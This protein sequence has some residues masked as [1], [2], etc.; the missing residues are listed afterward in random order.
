MQID[1]NGRKHF[2]FNDANGDKQGEIIVQEAEDGTA[3]SVTIR[4][5]RLD[6]TLSKTHRS[7]LLAS[8]GGNIVLDGTKDPLY[9]QPLTVGL[10]LMAAVPVS[11]Y[12]ATALA[13]VAEA[14]AKMAAMR[15]GNKRQSR[16]A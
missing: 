1:E 12:D 6:S 8:S 14:K 13:A 5:D 7:V 10:N 3:E 2:A 15:Q 9:G 16:I 4:F 11:E